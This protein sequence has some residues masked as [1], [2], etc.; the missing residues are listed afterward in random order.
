MLNAI[1]RVAA[2]AVVGVS[3]I[4]PIVAITTAAHAGGAPDNYTFYAADA[5][6]LDRGP[7]PA[8]VAGNV[9]RGALR[10]VVDLTNVGVNEATGTIEAWTCPKGV[11]PPPLG[12]SGDTDPRPTRCTFE[13]TRYLSFQLP[14]IRVDQHLS[15]ASLVGTAT[16]SDPSG[17]LSPARVR[18]AVSL[19]A[20]AP[21]VRKISI[22][23]E[24]D[25]DGTR[26]TRRLTSAERPSALEG[27]VGTTRLG[28]ERSDVTTST[29]SS[30]QLIT[31]RS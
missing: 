1:H 16:A 17:A 19:R 31:R 15:S 30:Q 22:T 12:V 6:W 28:D 11:Q 20:S 3:G 25:D 24:V 8:H 10:A 9:Y 14:K 21:A 23:H 5:E 26:V 4:A 13:G 29:I 7:V 18:V 2:V 27:T